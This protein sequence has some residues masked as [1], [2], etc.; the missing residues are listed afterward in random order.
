MEYNFSKSMIETGTYSYLAC[1]FLSNSNKAAAVDHAFQFE[2]YDVTKN[3][4]YVCNFLFSWVL[5][6]GNR[7]FGK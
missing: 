3:S 7:P 1:A 2:F 4:V 6:I 5:C